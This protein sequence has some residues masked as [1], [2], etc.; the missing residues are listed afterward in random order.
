MTT[1]VIRYDFRG[2]NIA[3][4]ANAGKL[5]TAAPISFEERQNQQPRTPLNTALKAVCW[6]L[7]LACI[8]LGAYIIY[9]VMTTGV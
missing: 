4:K 9:L 3:P 2:N 6:G 1:N 7:N 5:N 8:A